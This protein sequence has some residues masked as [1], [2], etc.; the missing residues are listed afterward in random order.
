M[1]KVQLGCK[2][3]FTRV[4]EGRQ[5]KKAIEVIVGVVGRNEYTVGVGN[6]EMEE[7][8]AHVRRPFPPSKPLNITKAWP[9]YQMCHAILYLL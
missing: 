6:L 2:E 1:K 8:R 5:D 4:G 3:C 7:V 9:A